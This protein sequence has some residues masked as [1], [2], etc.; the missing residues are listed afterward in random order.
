MSELLFRGA[1]SGVSTSASGTRTFPRTPNPGD[2]VIAVV[3][4]TATMALTLSGGGGTWAKV[5]GEYSNSTNF[6]QVWLGWGFDGSSTTYSYSRTGT[7]QIAFIEHLW[8]FP[9]PV[10]SQPTVTAATLATGTSVSAA[11]PS[12]TPAVN[13]LVFEL[14]MYANTTASSARTDTPGG[15]Q[16]MATGTGASLTATDRVET[17]Y[18]VATS[19]SALTRTWTITSAAWLAQSFRI[20]PSTTAQTG[21]VDTTDV[22]S[23]P[24]ATPVT[25]VGFVYKGRSTAVSD[26]S[27][28]GV[29]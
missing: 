15:V 3:F 8:S 19:T 10:T 11:A 16:G 20:T 21:A 13:D 2:I 29:V 6:A 24:A 23:L 28:N 5:G 22:T 9:A 1:G 26:T 4:S 7:T 17:C 25:S 12:I 18:R 14:A 27:S